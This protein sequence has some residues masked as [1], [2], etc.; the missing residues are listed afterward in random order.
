MEATHACVWPDSCSDPFFAILLHI[1]KGHF[2]TG[3]LGSPA[4]V[5]RR[6]TVLN[7]SVNARILSLVANSQRH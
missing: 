2:K 4:E 3:R 1:E 5:T 6:A 7:S